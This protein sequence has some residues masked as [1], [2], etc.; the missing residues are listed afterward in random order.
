MLRALVSDTYQACEMMIKKKIEAFE[1]SHEQKP[2]Q[3]EHKTIP[4]KK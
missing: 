1:K 4:H 3:E 2:R